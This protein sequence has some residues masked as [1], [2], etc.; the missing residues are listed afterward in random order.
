MN[1]LKN[2]NI[3][4]ISRLKRAFSIIIGAYLTA[5]VSLIPLF[6]AVAGLFKGFAITTIIGITIGVLITR[7]CIFRYVEEH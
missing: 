7:A 4:V 5:V 3:N 2:K 1:S 6:W